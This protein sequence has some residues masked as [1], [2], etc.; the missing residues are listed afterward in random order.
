MSISS[1]DK[2][3][4]NKYSKKIHTFISKDQLRNASIKVCHGNDEI[5]T[6]Y[7]TEVHTNK[8]DDITFPC[9]AQLVTA[10]Q[11]YFDCDSSVVGYAIWMIN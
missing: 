11:E 9:D 8:G 3:Y 4:F 5:D 2:K 7:Y 1:Y 6:H 10:F